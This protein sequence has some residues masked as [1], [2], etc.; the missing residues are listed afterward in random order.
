MGEADGRD[1]GEEAEGD[2]EHAGAD[3]RVETEGSR[4]RVGEVSHLK[5]DEEYVGLVGSW[6]KIFR[7]LCIINICQ[8]LRLWH[9]I[10]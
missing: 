8:Q 3:Q 9:G 6:V 2:G 7:S 1:A 10:V 4:Q 5:V